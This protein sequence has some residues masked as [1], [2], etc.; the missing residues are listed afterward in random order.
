EL[1]VDQCSSPGTTTTSSNPPKDDEHDH[2]YTSYLALGK[3]SRY[4]RVT[5]HTQDV[6][7]IHGLQGLW[8]TLSSFP[9][10]QLLQ[11]ISWDESS[12]NLL[13]DDLILEDDAWGTRDSRMLS[14][15]H[16]NNP[17]VLEEELS[18]SRLQVLDD[19]G[20]E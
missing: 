10:R 2:F 12:V 5:G 3:V 15:D 17:V 14:A 18:T 8:K 20:E 7:E 11:V 6:E 19:G 13:R 16:A 9:E 4:D 1:Q